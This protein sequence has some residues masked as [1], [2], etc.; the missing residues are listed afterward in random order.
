MVLG[1]TSRQ[2]SEG[3]TPLYEYLPQR[4]GEVEANNWRS[5]G[6]NG[7][8]FEEECL[9][10]LTVNE[11]DTIDVSRS[12]LGY[13]EMY[14]NG[15]HLCRIHFTDSIKT[16]VWVMVDLFEIKIISGKFYRVLVDLKGLMAN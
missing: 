16:P 13:C 5:F 12:H 2:P 6:R 9:E 3:G 1:I 14:V 11:G 15:K 10:L 4:F 7:T 8:V